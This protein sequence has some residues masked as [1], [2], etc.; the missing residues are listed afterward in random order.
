MK[1][2][3]TEAK[4]R[5]QKK[6]QHTASDDCFATMTGA[7]LVG[8][9]RRQ[10]MHDASGLQAQTVAVRT[11]FSLNFQCFQNEKLNASASLLGRNEP[12]A[13]RRSVR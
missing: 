7:T 10:T 6:K 4:T 8:I 1:G 3:G 9:P 11:L 5:R 2:V 13:L 12:I